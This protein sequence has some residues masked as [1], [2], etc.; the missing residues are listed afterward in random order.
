MSATLIENE[1]SSLAKMIKMSYLILH[2]HVL[3]Y[4]AKRNKKYV[5]RSDEIHQF[6]MDSS[7]EI[8]INVFF[9]FLDFANVSFAS[10]GSI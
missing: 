2:S 5:K 1:L 9:K 10:G 7:M 4:T 8:I 3:R 6:W